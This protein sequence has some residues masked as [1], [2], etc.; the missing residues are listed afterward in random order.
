MGIGL[1]R[2]Q[3]QGDAVGPRIEVFAD[4]LDDYVDGAPDDERVH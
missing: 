1:P 3:L 2:E 4:P